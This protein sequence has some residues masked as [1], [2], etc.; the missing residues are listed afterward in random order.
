MLK[1][2]ILRLIFCVISNSFFYLTFKQLK[3]I[4][5]INSNLKQISDGPIIT[6]GLRNV[7]VQEDKK[8]M[9]F[10]RAAGNPMPIITWERETNSQQSI[11]LPNK[12]YKAS[13]ISLFKN[14]LIIQQNYIMI[15]FDALLNFAWH[16]T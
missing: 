5:K 2:S 1:N 12:R 3:L 15:T 16:L 6:L 13:L 9:F 14:D 4:K 10:C 7:T 8:A 11:S